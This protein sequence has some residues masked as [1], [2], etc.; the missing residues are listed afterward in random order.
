MSYAT[1]SSSTGPIKTSCIQLREQLCKF[2]ISRM[3]PNVCSGDFSSL[4]GIRA[5]FGS[6][7]VLFVGHRFHL[8]ELVKSFV[9][10][11]TISSRSPVDRA[12][13][14]TNERSH[15]TLDPCHVRSPEIEN[16]NDLPDFRNGMF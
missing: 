5:R 4:S 11:A 9:N 15:A 2:L 12:V 16:M 1:I 3:S 6:S 7:V 10:S 8:V 13:S 14:V